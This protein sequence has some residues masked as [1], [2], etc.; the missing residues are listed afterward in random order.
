MLFLR[1][2]S[3]FTLIELL[4]VI[5]IISVLIGLLL[6]AVQ[7][8]REAASRLQ[9]QNN[10]KQIGLALHNYHDARGSFPS[11]RTAIPT[12]IGLPAATFSA[13]TFLLPFMEQDN[14]YRTVNFTVNWN[15]PLNAVPYGTL[16]SSY[17]C[18]SDPGRG[19][20]PAGWAPS[21]YRAN[22]GSSTVFRITAANTTVVPQPN[23]PF[24]LLSAFKLTDI[25]DGTSNTAAFSE[26][27]IGDFSNAVVT[28]Q[29]D[30]FIVPGP[31]PQNPDEAYTVCQSIDW[32]SL[33]YQGYSNNGGPWLAGAHS[34]TCFNMAEVPFARQCSFGSNGTQLTPA[35]SAHTNGVNLL[36]CDGS[37]RFVA[38]SIDA[39]TWRAM[40]SR[41]GGEVIGGSN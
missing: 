3:A 20:V 35:T 6:P 2:R 19:Q 7:K 34:T 40:G 21:S 13:Q 27:L 17:V 23:G 16:I 10:L 22:E 14:V 39:A 28:E 29:T 38:R 4:V 1:R 12:G 26:R 30:G 11:S 33:T 31:T 9:C 15:D 5:S 24:F 36:M 8:V 41:N 32:Q 25:T 18:P 37:L